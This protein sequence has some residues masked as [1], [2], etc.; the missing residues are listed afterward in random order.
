MG[1]VG[2]KH[3]RMPRDV[4]TQGGE[5]NKMNHLVRVAALTYRV[6]DRSIESLTEHLEA[7]PHF[8]IHRDRGRPQGLPD[9]FR[10][11]EKSEDES[12]GDKQGRHDRRWNEECG[13]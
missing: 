10:A 8:R 12:M 4:V 9:S 3:W 1:T 7:L 11:N 6:V 13:S 2:H 5:R